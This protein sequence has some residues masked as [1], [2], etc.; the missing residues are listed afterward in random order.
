[1]MDGQAFSDLVRAH[2][3]LEMVSVDAGEAAV[4]LRRPSTGL[5]FRL[6][7]RAVLD[8]EWDELHAVFSGNRMPGVLTHMT[9]IVGYYSRIENWNKSKH[10]ELADRR[11]G[12]YSLAG[13]A[14]VPAPSARRAYSAEAAASAVE[15]GSPGADERP[16]PV[17]V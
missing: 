9:R 17:M 1:M 4:Y 8:Y 2:P 13:R 11:K 14:P 7:L 12:D 5:C 10:S 3:D 16:K 6:A 15:A